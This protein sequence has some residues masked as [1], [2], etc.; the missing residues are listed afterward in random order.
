MDTNYTYCSDKGQRVTLY[1]P[2]DLGPPET[3]QLVANAE[4]V[5]FYR[6]SDRPLECGTIPGVSGRCTSADCHRRVL[7]KC[8]CGRHEA[9]RV[10]KAGS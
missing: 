3:L 1:A 2:P 6:L 9:V 5:T 4:R 8:Q 10:E 7:G